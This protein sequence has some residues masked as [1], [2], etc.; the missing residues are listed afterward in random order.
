MYDH[1]T[2]LISAVCDGQALIVHR[3]EH[4]TSKA[5]CAAAVQSSQSDISIEVTVFTANMRYVSQRQVS[6]L[7]QMIDEASAADTGNEPQQSK[8][9]VLL[10]HFLPGAALKDSYPAL[11]L[12]DWN[13]WYLDSCTG[14]VSQ[15]EMLHM[16][17]WAAA[18]AAALRGQPVAP[19]QLLGEIHWSFPLIL[20]EKFAILVKSQPDGPKC[21]VAVVKSQPDSHTCQ[22]TA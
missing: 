5:A 20:L 1:T 4:L 8:K 14:G 11:F 19:Q 7:R 3:L 22:V 10:L 13:F 21:Q 12:Y 17:S 15:Q 18:A 2:K 16:P 9:W 6:M